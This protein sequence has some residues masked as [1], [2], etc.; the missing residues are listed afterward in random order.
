MKVLHIISG[1]LWGGAESQALTLLT[2]LATFERLS[3]AVALMNEGRLAQELRRVGIPIM[4]LSERELGVLSLF[5]RLRRQI[6]DWAPDI[7]HTHREKENVLG[8]L[9]NRMA[10][11]AV[12]V[13]TVHGLPEPNVATTSLIKRRVVRFLD[14]LTATYLQDSI[15]CVSNDLR[16]RLSNEYPAERLVAIE[17]GIDAA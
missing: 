11:G 7:V 4:V 17:N 15:I 13:R 3:L 14:K 6:C 2:S 10:H 8:A 12:C 9:A 5:N 16:D 1:D